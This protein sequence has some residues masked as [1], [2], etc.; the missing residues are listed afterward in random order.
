MR[1]TTENLKIG[2]KVQVYL[3]FI[4]D[5]DEMTYAYVHRIKPSNTPDHYWIKFDEF[6]MEKEFH[7]DDVF[8][9]EL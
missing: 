1:T 3:W 2:D 4:D 9:K 6:A 5:N 8:E 7:K